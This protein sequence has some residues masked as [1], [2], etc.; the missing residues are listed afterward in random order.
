VREIGRSDTSLLYRE[1][2]QTDETSLLADRRELAVAFRFYP[3]S[4]K[5]AQSPLNCLEFL[6][7]IQ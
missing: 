4:F 2:S 6:N 5:I 1:R 7:V 3:L